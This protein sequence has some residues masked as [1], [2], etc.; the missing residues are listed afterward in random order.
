MDQDDED[1]INVKQ[2]NVM[3]LETI[4]DRINETHQVTAIRE[5]FGW[6]IQIPIV[7]AAC[8]QALDDEKVEIM[9][10]GPRGQRVMTPFLRYVITCKVTVR[11]VDWRGVLSI[12][13]R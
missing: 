8:R 11:L 9:K 7:L 5:C 4:I 6:E 12:I 1:I 3:D 13:D 2:E 10:T